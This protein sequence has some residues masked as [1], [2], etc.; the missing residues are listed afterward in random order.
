MEF[1]LSDDKGRALLKAL[2]KIEKSKK[3]KPSIGLIDVPCILNTSLYDP[4]KQ[5]ILVV[6]M[7]AHDRVYGYTTT[8]GCTPRLYRTFDAALRNFISDDDLTK[9]FQSIRILTPET[10]SYDFV[11]EQIIVLLSRVLP[12]I[13][14]C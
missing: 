9:S 11:Y 14:E 1:V 2:E 6:K 5:N 8:S 13:I 10:N 12:G 7:D 4:L 3:Q